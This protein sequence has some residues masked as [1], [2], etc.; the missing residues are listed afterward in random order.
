[1][2]TVSVPKPKNQGGHASAPTQVPSI[3]KKSGP[4]KPGAEKI[5]YGYNT[6]GKGGSGKTVNSVKKG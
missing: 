4:A 1:M 2:A 6:A 3:Q 5:I